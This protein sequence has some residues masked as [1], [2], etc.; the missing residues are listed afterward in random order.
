MSTRTISTK[1]LPVAVQAYFDLYNTPRFAELMDLIS[2]QTEYMQKRYFKL[3]D[4]E[5]IE[6]DAKVGA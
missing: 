1:E 3:V 4:A 5:R 6:Q 2:E